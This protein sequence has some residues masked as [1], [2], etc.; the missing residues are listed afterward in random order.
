MATTPPESDYVSLHSFG[1]KLSKLGTPGGLTEPLKGVENQLNVKGVTGCHLGYTD[2]LDDPVTPESKLCDVTDSSITL[3]FEN[4]PNPLRAYKL[5]LPKGL[6]EFKLTSTLNSNGAYAVALRVGNVPKA[7]AALNNKD[8]SKTKLAQTDEDY[9]NLVKG[10]ELKAAW[11]VKGTFATVKS[12]KKSPVVVEKT[13]WL[14]IY[15]TNS[16]NLSSIS[17]RYVFDNEVYKQ[18]YESFV[19][20]DEGETEGEPGIPDIDQPDEPPKPDVPSKPLDSSLVKGLILTRVNTTGSTVTTDYDK[21]TWDTV[22][23]TADPP[24]SPVPLFIVTPGGHV[25]TTDYN[26]TEVT[27]KVIKPPRFNPV[28]GTVFTL[29]AIDKLARFTYRR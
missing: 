1:V 20:N 4:I 13:Q 26:D 6:K 14:Y 8:F 21:E 9:A 25:V 18:E 27:I 11:D 17:A 24:G 23:V 7:T 3:N 28:E 19:F 16:V 5:L 12:S 15:T 10:V 29:T 2:Y 22:K